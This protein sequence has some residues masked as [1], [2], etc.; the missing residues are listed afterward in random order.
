MERLRDV[1]AYR[2]LGFGLREIADLV[3]DPS[4]DAVAH[5]RRLRGLLLQQRDRA[6]AI[7]T[8]IDRELRARAK[9]MTMAP[10]EQLGMFGAQLNDAIGGAYPATRRTEPRIA[11][12]V[13]AALGDAR[14]V[15]NVWAGTCSYEPP[16]RDVT[17]VEPTL[18]ASRSRTARR[19]S[20]ARNPSPDTRAGRPYWFTS[21]ARIQSGHTQDGLFRPLPAVIFIAMSASMN[22]RALELG[23]GPAELPALLHVPGR[24]HRRDQR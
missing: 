6:D 1:L 18:R 19:G 22:C 14:T 9:G 12:Q 7:M 24:V 21:Y 3:D 20:D 16:D 5:L 4:T 15:L 11:A 8:G 2:R 17:A 23:D 13:W 10:E